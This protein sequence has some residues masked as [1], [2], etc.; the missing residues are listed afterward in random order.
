VIDQGGSVVK[1]ATHGGAQSP[2]RERVP[3]RDRP[4][5]ALREL[6][7]GVHLRVSRGEV[8][9][10]PIGAQQTPRVHLEQLVEVVR[11]GE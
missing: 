11:D 10:E 8:D 7:E 6:V 9:A 2:E 3:R 5:G 4:P 1:P